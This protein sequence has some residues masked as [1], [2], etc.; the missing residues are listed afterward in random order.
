MQCEYKLKPTNGSRSH[1]FTSDLSHATKIGVE[2]LNEHQD[3]QERQALFDW[4][5]STNFPSQ[6]SDI[7]SRCQ[8]GTGIW[9]ID[10]KE[11]HDWLNGTESTLFCPG[12][13]GAGK[14]MMTSI[15]IQ[16]L[17]ES[18]LSDSKIGIAY[19]FCSYKREAEQTIEMLLASLMKQLSQRRTT[20]TAEVKALHTHHKNSGVRPSTD[21]LLDVIKS[22]TKEF[23]RVYFLVDALDECS[24]TNGT[25]SRLLEA[26]FYLQTRTNISF[27]GTS[28]FMPEILAS[29]RGKSSLEIRASDEDVERYLQDHMISLPSFVSSNRNLQR[30]IQIKIV[31][32][33][34]GMCVTSKTLRDLS[35][36]SWLTVL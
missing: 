18:F 31:R 11:Y 20:L 32:A 30:T 7:I 26:V 9:L 17:Q 24:N 36:L 14:T 33:V 13:P 16:N 3:D 8:Q 22:A 29:F 34:E 28:R 23:S 25:R 12:I 1:E 10:S 15:V 4:L 35:C 21:K 19:L 2:R 5:S 27:F 6:Q